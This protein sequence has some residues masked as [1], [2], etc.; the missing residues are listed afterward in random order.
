MLPGKNKR[1]SL[2]GKNKEAEDLAQKTQVCLGTGSNTAQGANE[3]YGTF[4]TLGDLYIDFGKPGEYRNYHKE[5][6]LNTGI[7]SVSYQLDSNQ[8][9]RTYFASYP[10]N[11]IVIKIESAQKKH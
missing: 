6:S 7:A 1:T 9:K 8:I 5:L 10:D 11:V 3:P 4:Q 2:S